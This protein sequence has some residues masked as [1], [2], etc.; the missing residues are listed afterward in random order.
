MDARARRLP[1]LADGEL[2]GTQE[3]EIALSERL[4]GLEREVAVDPIKSSDGSC[5]HSHIRL[6]LHSMNTLDHVRNS[7][8]D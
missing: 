4:R 1:S 6:L 5:L 8:P 2:R 7:P 3:S